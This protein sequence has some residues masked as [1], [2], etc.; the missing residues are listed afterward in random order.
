MGKAI[1]GEFNAAKFWRRTSKNLSVITP[2]GA[3]LRARSG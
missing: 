1:E 2:L 3:I